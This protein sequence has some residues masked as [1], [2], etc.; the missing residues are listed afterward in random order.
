MRWQQITPRFINFRLGRSYRGIIKGEG[1][2][3][4]SD[5]IG[6]SG[7]SPFR[8]SPNKTVYESCRLIE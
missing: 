8:P 4:R 5:H 2:D 1:R 7:S 3:G 6:T